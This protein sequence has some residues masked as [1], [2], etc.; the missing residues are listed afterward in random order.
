[1]PPLPLVDQSRVHEFVTVGALLEGALACFTINE[2][3]H[4]GYYMAHF[5]KC[6]PQ[7]RGLSDLLESE[8]ARLM[9]DLG[10]SQ[11]NFQQDL[12][13]PGLRRYKRSWAAG[14]FLKKFSI[15]KH[16]I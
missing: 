4:D 15:G 11:M 1:M 16:S 14:A 12:G 7:R 10:C 13:L 9:R 2:A 8:T 6:D 5:G 3:I